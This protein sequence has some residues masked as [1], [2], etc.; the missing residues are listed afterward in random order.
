MET[1][2]EYGA[3]KDHVFLMEN[4]ANPKHFKFSEECEWKDK[5]VYL[6]KIEKR[7]RQYKFQS[8]PN[9]DFIGKFQSTE[10]DI[11]NS[12]YL[13]EVTPIEKLFEDLTK[14][15]NMVLLSDGENGSPGKP[16]I[17]KV[18]HCLL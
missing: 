1:F 10:F 9:I 14:Y 13:G 5:S 4:G 8:I 18:F 12:N 11:N 2:L 16:G 15:A 7:K 3:D 17:K 6:G